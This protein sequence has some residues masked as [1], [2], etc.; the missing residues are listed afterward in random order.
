MQHMK[1]HKAKEFILKTVSLPRT[2]SGFFK[3][4]NLG[5]SFSGTVLSV[6]GKW[7]KVEI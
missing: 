2:F 7:Q 4:I 6:K 1:W 3:I 5:I